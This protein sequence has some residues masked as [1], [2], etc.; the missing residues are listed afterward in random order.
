MDKGTLQELRRYAGDNQL[1]LGTLLNQIVSG[2]MEWDI[3]AERAGYVTI[4]KSALKELVD[5]NDTEGLVKIA[6]L[7]TKNFKDVLLLT[8]GNIDLE[9]VLTIL[10]NSARRSGFQYRAFND[11]GSG[12]KIIIQHDMGKK[13]S[14]FYKERIQEMIKNSGHS[15]KIDTV[16]DNKLMIAI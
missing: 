2:Y 5:N 16:D 10:E 12:K 11:K 1:S 8:G 9:T 3:H 15:A 6:T 14:F 13:W 4:E 7:A